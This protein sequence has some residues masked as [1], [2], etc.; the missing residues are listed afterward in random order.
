MRVFCMVMAVCCVIK[1]TINLCL[2]A[3]GDKDS[4]LALFGMIVQTTIAVW[5]FYVLTP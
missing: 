5:G 1:A 4:G 3:K 2:V